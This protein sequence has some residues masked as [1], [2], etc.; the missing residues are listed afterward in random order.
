MWVRST[1][2]VLV[3]CSLGSGAPVG[4]LGL[5]E[6]MYCWFREQDGQ[7]YETG[8]SVIGCVS[9]HPRVSQT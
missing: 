9:C 5:D 1:K 6:C 4:V 8:Q 7:P 3:I 2:G